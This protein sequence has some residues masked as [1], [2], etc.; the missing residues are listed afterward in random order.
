MNKKF[1]KNNIYLIIG[2]LIGATLACGITAYATNIM[3]G[4]VTYKNNKTVEAALNELYNRTNKTL[5]WTNPNPNSSFGN[6]TITLSSSLTGYTHFLLIYKASTADETQYEDI[7]KI[8]PERTKL[9]EAGN[10]T[11]GA[12]IDDTHRGRNIWYNSENSLKFGNSNPFNCNFDD[13]DNTVLIPL[14]IYGLNLNI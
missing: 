11:F 2:I 14:Y 3:A 4:N 6:D 1:E 10:Y 9:T 13:F 8:A 7:F 5:L 12:T